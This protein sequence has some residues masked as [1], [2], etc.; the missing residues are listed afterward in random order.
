MQR[1]L[2][3]YRHLIDHLMSELEEFLESINVDYDITVGTIKLYD[4]RVIPS[5]EVRVSTDPSK[6]WGDFYRYYHKKYGN[7]KFLRHVDIYF[8]GSGSESYI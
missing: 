7:I 1:E 6:A 3:K 5:I 4:G 8:T 2:K